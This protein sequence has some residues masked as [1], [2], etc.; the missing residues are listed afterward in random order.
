MFIVGPH[1]ISK[2]V[3]HKPHIISK[4]LIKKPPEYNLEA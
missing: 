1:I 2:L 3:F 4:S